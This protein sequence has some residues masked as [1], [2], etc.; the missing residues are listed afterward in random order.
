MPVIFGKHRREDYCTK[1]TTVDADKNADCPLWKKF[2]LRIMGNDQDMVNY[3]QR[4][5]GYC[6]TGFTDEH[7]MFFGWGTGRNG[8]SVFA[9]VLTGI[10]GLGPSGYAAIAPISTFLASNNEQHPTDLAML[11][12]VR[13]VIAQE[14]EQGRSWATSKLKM[15]TGGDP[16]TARFM[17][18][19]FFTYVPRFKIMVLGNHKPQF[20][21]VDE[22]IRARLHLIPFT[23][24]IP[25]A[26]RDPRLAEK[27]KAEYPAIL[28]WMM[29]GCE[30][31]DEM[32]LPKVRDATSTYLATED[33]VT[34]WIADRCI[35][36]VDG[37][38]IHKDLFTSWG[39]W[40]KANGDQP[41]GQSKELAKALDGRPNLKRHKI[42]TGQV[43]WKGIRLPD[44]AERRAAAEDTR[45]AAAEDEVETTEEAASD[46]QPWWDR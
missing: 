14:T 38:T 9:S 5:C 1:A 22:A 44:A 15:M 41:P 2:L 35:L 32:G 16:I 30:R 7:A 43:G 12:G 17:R 33:N 46:A 28:W 23:V 18:Q 11:Q 20:H 29:Q 26:E 24:F 40:C 6:L 3:L 42:R 25:E 13:L 10:M 36:D 37:F 31:W 19:D 45:R 21:N 8:K 27:L 4:V 39:S 34:N